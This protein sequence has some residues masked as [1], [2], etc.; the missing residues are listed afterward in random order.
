M[1]GRKEG[2]ELEEEEEEDK[3][4]K[5]KVRGQIGQLRS[6]RKDGRLRPRPGE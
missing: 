5:A 4:M 3:C 2:K 1:L 6:R